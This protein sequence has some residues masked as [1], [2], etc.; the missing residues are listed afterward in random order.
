MAKENVQTCHGVDKLNSRQK[1]VLRELVCF[2]WEHCK[3]H[4]DQCGT[5]QAHRVKR[6]NKGGRYNPG[7]IMMICNK[8]H[9]NIHWGEFGG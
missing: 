9:K 7:N 4:E 1:Q 5:L 2:I 3:R 8:C 6:G